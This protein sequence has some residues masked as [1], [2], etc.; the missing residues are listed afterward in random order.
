MSLDFKLAA[1]FLWIMPFTAKRS[2][3]EMVSGSLESAVSLGADLSFLIAVFNLE[4]WAEFRSL[5]RSAWRARFSADL[6]VAIDRFS[7]V[8]WTNNIKK[9]R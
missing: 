9:Q 6:C 4:R 8:F 1:L 5:R 3:K 2:I 7:L